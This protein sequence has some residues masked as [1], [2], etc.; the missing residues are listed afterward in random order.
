MKV[1]MISVTLDAVIPMMR[2]LRQLP[3]LKVT[4]YLDEGLRELVRKEGGVTFNSIAR[5]TGIMGHA[6]YDGADAVLL[7]CTVFTPYLEKLQNL[8]SVP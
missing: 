2:E 3:S 8:F 5:M 4:N 6:L 1:A 7:T